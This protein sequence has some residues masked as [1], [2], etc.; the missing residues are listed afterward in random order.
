MALTM[1]CLSWPDLDLPMLS[2]A[3]SSLLGQMPCSGIFR[4]ANVESSV[5]LDELLRTAGDFVSS[6]QTLPALP[7]EQ[8]KII[9]EK[10]RAEVAAGLMT[11]PCTREEMTESLVQVV[12]G[13]LSDSRSA[14]PVASGV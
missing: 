3:G 1:A 10:T 13:P 4:P 11:Q 2:M 9:W 8:S 14:K 5:S 7:P 12:G 6:V